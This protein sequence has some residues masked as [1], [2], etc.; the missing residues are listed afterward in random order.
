MLQDVEGIG[1]P[2]LNIACQNAP[3]S[4]G[5]DM[6]KKSKLW[7]RSVYYYLKRCM[8]A[9][10]SQITTSGSNIASWTP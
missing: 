8:E 4:K 5:F 2:K 10:F 6:G 3:L 1:H 7:I 9:R